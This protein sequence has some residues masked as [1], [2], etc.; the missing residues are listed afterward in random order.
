MKILITG[1]AGFIGSNFI[2]FLLDNYD[3]QIINIDKLTYA[4]N[5]DNLGDISS[6]NNY[7]FYQG[8]ILDKKFIKKVFDKSIDY[9]VNFA[10]ETHVDRS[11]E[12]SNQF[13]KTNVEGTQVLL[14]RALECNIKNFVQIST[15]EVYGSI[16][17]GKFNENNKLKPN[18]PY[19]A[20]KA[21]ADLLLKAYHNTYNLPVNITRSSNNY[22]PY[23]YPEKFIPLFI[24]N[25]IQDKKIPLY[26]DGENIRDWIYVKDNC[27]A[28][29]LVMRKGKRGEIYNIG[30]NNEKSNIEITKAIL[31]IMN[32][33]EDII[34]YVEDRPGHDY[35]YA[36]NNK[37]IRN[38]LGWNPKI[39]FYK[40]L[41]KT[42]NWYQN[43]EKWWKI[44]K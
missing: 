18:N 43:N 17:K 9:V 1:G 11:I 24:T 28:I 3:D 19:S 40:G 41:R 30:A 4:G 16:N 22:G 35:R 42:I 29:D 20:S 21:S 44:L 12:N 39:S 34:K 13:I 7:E 25:I 32:K 38:E 26:G 8:D 6:N 5:L 10:A 37:K 33:S 14:D 36:L 27:K 15:D 31:K 2:H 23:Q